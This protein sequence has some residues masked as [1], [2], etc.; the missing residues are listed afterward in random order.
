MKIFCLLLLLIPSVAFSEVITEL[1]VNKNVIAITFDACETKTPSYF[2]QPILNF[3]I[4]E[5]IPC[6]IFISEK[7]ARRNSAEI[8][9][10][11]SLGFIEIE[12]HS[13]NHIQHMERLSKNDVLREID[14]KVLQEITGKKTK[15]FRFP[16]GNY[17]DKTL[18]LVEKQFKVVH[19]TFASGDA[20]KRISPPM[21][22]QWVLSKAKARS[23]LIFHINGRGYSTGKALPEIIKGLSLKGYKFVK[24]EDAI[25]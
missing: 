4:K 15:Y 2:D 25:R 1:P 20:D 16:A 7:F 17:N 21:L 18:K 3:L 11:V 12:N 19:W 9:R 5:K 24:L 6:T 23:I 22:T 14:D 10:I 13:V 8:K